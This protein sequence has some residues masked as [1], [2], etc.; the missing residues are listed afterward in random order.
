MKEKDF[1]YLIEALQEISPAFFGCVT[2][3]G[4]IS[5]VKNITDKE[6]ATAERLRESQATTAEK[7]VK[8]ADKMLLNDAI[9]FG[10]VPDALRPAYESLLEA[11]RSATR[12]LLIYSFNT[13]HLLF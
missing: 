8:L 1:N 6:K 3:D 12:Q 2:I 5:A 9:N 10:C 13:T 4:I 7:I 11:D